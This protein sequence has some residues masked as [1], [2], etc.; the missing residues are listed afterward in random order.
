MVPVL[1]VVL[2]TG[3]AAT[4]RWMS[5]RHAATRVGGGMNWSRSRGEVWSEPITYRFLYPHESGAVP[6]RLT[7]ARVVEGRI[8]E[9]AT[10]SF[11]SLDEWYEWAPPFFAAEEGWTSRMQPGWLISRW[12]CEDESGRCTTG[13]LFWR[14]QALRYFD[15]ESFVNEIEWIEVSGRTFQILPTESRPHYDCD[16]D[17]LYW[18]PSATRYIPEDPNLDRRWHVTTPSIALASALSH[19]YYDLC[20]T[21]G[22]A[23]GE[24]WETSVVRDENRIRHI[25]FLKDPACSQI[26][27]R[28]G[29]R[30]IWPDVP[31]NSPE[32]AWWDYRGRVTY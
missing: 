17:T 26:W 11:G 19:A 6:G 10:W 8:R 1:A 31:G 20:R 9:N 13:Q 24:G 4:S 7:F 21:G 12:L 18:N 25:L 28:P 30:E 5:E 27:P 2:I 23:G 14:I 29:W 16:A 15:P 32:R 22:A 3:V